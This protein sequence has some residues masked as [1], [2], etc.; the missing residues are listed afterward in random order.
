MHKLILRLRLE[1]PETKVVERLEHVIWRFGL[2]DNL[3]RVEQELTQVWTGRVERIKP[4]DRPILSFFGTAPIPPRA[5]I[6]R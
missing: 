3:G 1:Q 4:S 2:Q 5:D 6:D